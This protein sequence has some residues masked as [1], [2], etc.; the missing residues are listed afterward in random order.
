M[1]QE[2]I[3][4]DMRETKSDTRFPPDDSRQPG[5]LRHSTGKE[6]NFRDRGSI[7]DSD[8]WR[9]HIRRDLD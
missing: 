1:S 3:R 6:R 5:P 8:G 7:R 2:Q 9:E 4:S